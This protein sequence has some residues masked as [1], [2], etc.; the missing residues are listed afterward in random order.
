MPEYL[1]RFDGTTCL[2]TTH[3]DSSSYVS[4]IIHG[5]SGISNLNKSFFFR[6]HSLWNSLPF[7]IRNISNP[8]DFNSQITEYFWEQ[9]RIDINEYEDSDISSQDHSLEIE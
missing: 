9:T 2:R 4:S 5:T 1:N 7:D 8:K 3:L 6:I